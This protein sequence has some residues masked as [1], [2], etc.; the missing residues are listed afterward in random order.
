MDTETV[1][2]IENLRADFASLRADFGS[3]RAD[4]GSLR[5]DFGSLRSEVRSDIDVLRSEVRELHGDAKR[6]ADVLFENLRDD[7]RMVAEAVV[8]LSAKV[9]DRL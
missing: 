6:H 8:A 9:E 7:I 3:L 1:E 5:A 2:A 4:F